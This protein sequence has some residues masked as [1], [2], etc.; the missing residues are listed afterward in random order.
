MFVQYILNRKQDEEMIH[1]WMQKNLFHSNLPQ[2]CSLLQ[3]VVQFWCR[4]WEDAGFI[5]VLQ[6]FDDPNYQII[7]ILIKSNLQPLYNY[8][9]QV[10]LNWENNVTLLLYQKL[11]WI[12]TERRE[13]GVD[14][15]DITTSLFKEDQP[16]F[17]LRG[18]TGLEE[19]GT[20]NWVTTSW[21]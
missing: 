19:D 16:F 5:E 6:A 17:F 13:V 11:S 12:Q 4:N 10:I 1:S 3:L 8:Y 7:S 9:C 15:G 14:R 20:G 2:N 21:Y 18:A